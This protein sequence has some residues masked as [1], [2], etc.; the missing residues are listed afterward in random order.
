MHSAPGCLRL[1]DVGAAC[2][3]LRGSRFGSLRDVRSI[4]CLEAVA[5]AAHRLRAE[6]L[7][8]ALCVAAIGHELAAGNMRVLLSDQPCSGGPGAA[9][10]FACHTLNVAFA[11]H[12][13]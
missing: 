11:A 6:L 2:P 13:L 8:Q 3:L 4:L 5:G 9:C 7:E 1:L 12:I 10:A